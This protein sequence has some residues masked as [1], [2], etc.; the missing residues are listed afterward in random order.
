[1]LL[2]GWLDKLALLKP[3]NATKWKALPS[4]RHKAYIAASLRVCNMH[5][6]Q[7]LIIGGGKELELWRFGAATATVTGRE[8]IWDK[9]GIEYSW[10]DWY[11]QKLLSLQS[12]DHFFVWNPWV[13]Y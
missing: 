12:Y 6:H 1:M 10:F 5:S 4:Q 2:F 7:W 3:G 8:A 9:A 11:L 13:K